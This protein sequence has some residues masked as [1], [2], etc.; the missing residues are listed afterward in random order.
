MPPPTLDV[1]L[2]VQY[3]PWSAYS[4]GGQRSTHN[5]ACALAERDHR[6]TVVYTKPPLERIVPPEGLPYRLLWAALPAPTSKRNNVGRPLAAWTTAAVVKRCL[7]EAA[8]PV[9]VHANGD[10]GGR[11][12]RL[13]GHRD[14]ALVSTVRFPAMP[15]AL[16]AERTLLR[17][18][19]ILLYYPKHVLQALAARRA[20]R[21]APPSRWVGGLIERAYG[22]VA[23]LAPVHNGVPAEFLR[24]ERRPGAADGPI[25]FF[26]RFH[27]DK[28]VDV[29]LEALARLGPDGPPV[30]IIGRGREE[31][32]LRQQAAAAGLGR[33]VAFVPWMD[34]DGL[35]RELARAR[36]AVLPS[37]EENFSLAV[38]GALGTGCPTIST[39]AGGT[40]EMI[41]DGETGLLVPPGDTRALAAAL[42]RLARDHA[43][44]ARLGAAGRA[45]VASQFRWADHYGA[46]ERLYADAVGGA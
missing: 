16:L 44:A 6:V 9:V 4:G 45:R 41:V 7:L 38:L 29:L 10:E 26:G 13:R 32:R 42:E 1:V 19:K 25:V 18:G 31:G 30:R 12:H 23:P 36:L 20:D 33:R 15:R 14:F 8:G 40:P 46:I 11:L 24:H 17:R 21:C 27:P 39:T 43:L 3:S 28:G 34:H 2:T 22:P 35:A 5:L 37:R